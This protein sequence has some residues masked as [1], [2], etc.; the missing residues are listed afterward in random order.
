MI[1]KERAVERVESLLATMQPAHELVVHEVKEHAWGWLVFWNSAQYARTRDLRDLLVGAGPYLVDRYDGSVH[2]IPVTTWVGEDWEE[3]YL[4]QIKGCGRTTPGGFR[5]GADELRRDGGRDASPPQ[6][7]SALEPA[8][9]EDLRH[10]RPKRS[11]A[12]TRT[13]GPHQKRRGLPASGDRNSGRPGPSV[14]HV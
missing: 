14:V 13:G 9:G 10:G 3:L 8:T 11:R 7:G 5:A 2:H 12:A 4:R 1:S 6:A